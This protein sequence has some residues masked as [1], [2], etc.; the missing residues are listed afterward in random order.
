MHALLCFPLSAGV[1]RTGTYVTLDNV[2]DQVKAEGLVDIDGIVVKARNQRMK[3]VQSKVWLFTA[4]IQSILVNFES[5]MNIQSTK[6][7]NCDCT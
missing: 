6:N 7:D 5:N 1:G 2:F 4:I 3:M